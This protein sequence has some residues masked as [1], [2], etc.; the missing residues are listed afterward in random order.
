VGWTPS[1]SWPCTAA[2]TGRWSR[3]SP[4]G[5]APTTPPG[6]PPHRRPQKDVAALLPE[7]VDLLLDA[8]TANPKPWLRA[9]TAL[10]AA[11]GA[12]NG[13]LCGLEWSDLDLDQGTV[14][15]REEL[16]VIDADLLPGCSDPDGRSKELA[17]GLR[18]SRIESV[19]VCRVRA[20]SRPCCSEKRTLVQ[21][22]PASISMVLESARRES[23]CE[24]RGGRVARIEAW[25]NA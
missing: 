11:T 22:C 15:F 1:T 21:C 10:A 13:E 18:A 23:E 6:T 17:V 14:R 8:A 16:T 2:C 4:D 20:S 7:Q 9:W 12:R 25:K 19:L 3:R 5:C 24:R